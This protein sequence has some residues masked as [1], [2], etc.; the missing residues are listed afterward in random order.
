MSLRCIGSDFALGARIAKTFDSV[1]N[2]RFKLFNK[3]PDYEEFLAHTAEIIFEPVEPFGHINLRIGKNI[4]SFNNVEW[5][6]INKFS[7]RMKK[8]SN[9][10]MPGSHGFVFEIGKEK[11][12]SMKKNIDAFYNSSSSHNIPPFDAYSPMLKITEIETTLGKNLKYETTSPKFGNEKAIKGK[13]ISEKGHYFLDTGNGTRV[14]VIKEDGHYFTQS[15]SCSSSA[16][17]ILKEFFNINVSYG[18]AAKSLLQSLLKGNLQE[19][20]SPIAVIKY[21]EDSK[22]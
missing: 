22:T 20:T 9:P 6:S 3:Y 11:I 19:K 7:P 18:D 8:S 5:T 16:A 15:Y 4:Y 12:E 13:I 2:M 10:E 17:Y 21:Y 1:Y 14:P